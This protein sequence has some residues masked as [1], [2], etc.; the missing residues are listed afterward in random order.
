LGAITHLLGITRA[1]AGFRVDEIIE[2][3][4]TAVRSTTR[5]ARGKRTVTVTRVIGSFR[6]GGMRQTAMRLARSGKRTVAVTRVIG[7]YG[8]GD[9]RQAAM[10]LA[11][12]GKRTVAVTRVI[13]SYGIGEMR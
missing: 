12:S 1:I 6:I 8:I 7:S 4:C 11:R 2:M 3:R 9:I 10:R 13:G 5:L